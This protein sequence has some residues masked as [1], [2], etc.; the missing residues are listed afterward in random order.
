MRCKFCGQENIYAVGFCKKCYERNLR[1]GSP[2]RKLARYEKGEKCSFCGREKAS[3][4]SLCKNCYH[5][6]WKNGSPE[7][8]RI[9][10]YD[11]DAKCS[12][13]GTRGVR[14]KGLCN[15]CHLRNLRHGNPQRRKRLRGE[16]SFGSQGY[17]IIQ[18]RNRCMKNSRLIMEKKIGRKLLSSEVVHHKNGNKLD[19]REENLEI[20]SLLEHARLHGRLHNNLKK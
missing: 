1:N 11:K 8:M 15:S 16:G 19:D 18:T 3:A 17:L 13:C 20:M 12:F 6:N 10:K 14:A 5:R 7:K 4:K 2:K 9:K